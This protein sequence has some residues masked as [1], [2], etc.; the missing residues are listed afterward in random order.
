MT[1]IDKPVRVRYA[2]SPTGLQHVGG[3]RTALYNYL[4][5]KK[6]GGQFILRIED[7]DQKRFVAGA[8]ENIMMFLK[9]FGLQYDEGPIFLAD[10]DELPGALS[11][12]YPGVYEKGSVGPYIQ[13]ERLPQY[14]AAVKQLVDAGHAYY[15][16][17]TEERLSELRERQERNK[18]PPR[19]DGLCRSLTLEA[20]KE[21]RSNGKSCV[22]RFRVPAGGIDIVCQDLLRGELKY[23]AADIEDFILLKSDGYP[24]YHLANIVDDHAM[25][26]SHVLRGEEWLSSLPKHVLLYEAFAWEKPLFA[27]L[28]VILGADGK[29]KLSKRDGDVSVDAFVEAGY[30]RE[31]LL[32][33]I[34]LLGWNPGK[35]STQEIFSLAELAEHFSLESLN[36][37]PAVFDRKKLDW[38]NHEYIMRLPVDE[39]LTRVRTLGAIEHAEWYRKAPTEFQAD[40]HLLKVLTVEQDRLKTLTDVGVNNPFFFTETL[41]YPTELLAWKG[42]TSERT[43]QELTRAMAV[44][45]AVGEAEWTRENLSAKL[46]EAAEKPARNTAPGAVGGKGDFLWPLRVALTG[47]E[48]SPSPMDTAWVLGKMETR[49]RI[50]HALLRLE[51]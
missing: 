45:E 8:V 33:F 1:Q 47:A 19:Y 12:R 5:A 42:N 16:F 40:A 31:A 48:R 22:V 7:T 37:A 24:T 38:M 25:G 30:L 41:E 39:L 36:A 46:L 11:T 10:K 49:K 44:L 3:L 23:K 14:E 27:H 18:Q 21:E 13:S 51:A 17:C 34:A 26:I 29:K 50:E 43:K 9:D 6:L 35:G 2:P 32:N 28:S 15:C 4:L 20:A